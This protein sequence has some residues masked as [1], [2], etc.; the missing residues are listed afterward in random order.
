MAEKVTLLR[1]GCP[2]REYELVADAHDLSEL[3]D[4]LSALDLSILRD[5]PVL[6]LLGAEDK[7]EVFSH[8]EF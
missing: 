6:V 2:R 8:G 1:K 3:A 7:F 5:N 4:Q